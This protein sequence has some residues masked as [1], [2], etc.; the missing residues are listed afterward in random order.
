VI[1]DVFSRYV[2]GWMV[3]HRESATLAKRLIA[4]TCERQKIGRGEL[5]LHA[6][7]GSSMKSKAVALL[8]SDLGVTKT[9]SRP[10][11]SDDNPYSETNFKTLKYRPEFPERFGSIEDARGISADLLWWYN[12]EHHHVGLGLLTPFDVHYGLAEEVRNVAAASGPTA[13]AR[14]FD[15][16][17]LELED[18]HAGE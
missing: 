3:A 18:V 14:V 13:L 12:H 2:V 9:P 5:T 4:E 11:V 15:E 16:T 7:W 8:L 1:L 10:H 6:D 17:G